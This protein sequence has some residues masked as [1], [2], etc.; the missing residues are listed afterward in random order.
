MDVPLQSS[1]S[2]CISALAET[3]MYRF[4]RL[5]G[6]KLSLRSYNALVGEIPAR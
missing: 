5:I 3:T 2:N 1:D 4:K 6:P